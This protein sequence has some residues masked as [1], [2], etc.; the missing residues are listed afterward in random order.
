[1]AIRKI[2]TKI[3]P[4]KQIVIGS[5][6]SYALLVLDLLVAF[7]LPK[8]INDVI[9]QSNYG[10][11]TLSNSLVAMF[12]IDFG[13]GT[14]VSKFL[15]KYVV[16][17]DK[18]GEK[19]FLG[20]IFKIYIAIDLIILCIF[21]VVYFLIDSIYA[22]LNP[23]ELVL[24]KTIF[25]IVAIYNLISFPFVPLEGSLVSHE[26]FIALK[27]FSFLQ[28]IIYVGLVSLFLILN[29]GVV[30]VSIAASISGLIILLFKILFCV[31]YCNFH[32]KISYWDKENA[33]KIF[34]FSLWASIGTIIM[35]IVVT[36]FPTILGVVS[37]SNNIS[38]FGYAYALECNA[39]SIATVISSMILPEVTK[40]ISKNVNSKE[41]LDEY[42]IKIGKIQS[43][44]I[45]LF[46]FGFIVFGQEFLTLLMGDGYINSYLCFIFLFL[47]N[48]LSCCFDVGRIASYVL[49]TIKYTTIIRTIASVLVVASSFVLGYYYGAIGICLSYCIFYLAAEI[50]S[51]IYLYGHK[52][53]MSVFKIAFRVYVPQ[54]IPTVIPVIAFIIIKYFVP[55][56]S[57]LIFAIFVFGFTFLYLLLFF[58]FG[59]DKV[60]RRNIVDV[61]AN[62]IFSKNQY[63]VF[64]NNSK[65]KIKGSKIVLFNNTENVAL[66]DINIYKGK[67]KVE[68]VYF[69]SNHLSS[70]N[71]NKKTIVVCKYN[72]FIDYNGILNNVK[73]LL[74]LLDKDTSVSEEYEKFRYEKL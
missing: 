43:F 36:I 14:A 17:N 26:Q 46:F 67:K 61:I 48:I 69:D 12:I 63:F 55:I 22:G 34:F 56:N 47:P 32:P 27:S 38:I 31:F 30:F 11:Y 28:K 3:N 53:K 10:V 57:W 74:V 70:L 23:D 68:C 24:L 42:A 5:I 35:K 51:I 4:K 7:F 64:I 6:I 15:T 33:K 37:D 1:M 50:I 72:D 59:L 62:K 52:Q 25:P 8:W 2:L 29:L 21:I 16:D 18:V 65:F 44:I 49:N 9:G 54:I 45:F 66:T 58:L 73:L 60:Q 71:F 13:L 41:R 20:I 19:N 40:I 39:F